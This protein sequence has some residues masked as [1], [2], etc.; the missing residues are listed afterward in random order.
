MKMVAA[1][2]HFVNSS[3]FPTYD[4]QF[5]VDAPIAFSFTE[6]LAV[7]RIRSATA[8]YGASDSRLWTMAYPEAAPLLD[9][10]NAVEMLQAYLHRCCRCIF[11][12]KIVYQRECFQSFFSFGFPPAIVLFFL[13]KNFTTSV[14]SFWLLRFGTFTSNC[15]PLASH[16]SGSF[17]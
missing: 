13:K 5:T 17:G 15:A 2:V 1:K 9:R 3:H 14:V 8:L 6:F 11:T 4:V 10:R 12:M 7:H 16:L